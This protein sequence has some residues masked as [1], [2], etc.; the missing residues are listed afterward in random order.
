MLDP[1]IT[2][3]FTLLINDV[4]DRCNGRSLKEAIFNDEKQWKQKRIVF[5]NFLNVLNN[6]ER[7]YQKMEEKEKEIEKEKKRLEREKQNLEKKT[8]K[9]EKRRST[10]NKRKAE[11]EIEETYTDGDETEEEDDFFKDP[12]DEKK[13]T[14]E[15]KKEK[16]IRKRKELFMFASQ[17]TMEGWRLTITSLLELIP[18]L[19]FKC[20]YKM[21]FTGKFNQDPVEVSIAINL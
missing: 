17:T 21:V 16:K 1:F 5:D 18:E 15:K 19:L 14:E 7:M 9:G 8:N 11:V 12:E 4:F 10:R 2:Q 20:G 3:Q 13:K 6:T